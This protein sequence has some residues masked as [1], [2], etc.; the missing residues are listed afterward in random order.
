MS[1]MA[2]VVL[3]LDSQDIGTFR[4]ALAYA[5]KIAAAAGAADV[6]LLTHT[7]DQLDN[8]GLSRFLEPAAVKALTSRQ[9]ASLP[10]G[11]KLHGETKRT[12]RSGVPGAVII[13]YYADAELLDAVDGLQGVSGVVAVP[14]M[15]GE[16]DSWAARWNPHV[17]GQKPVTPAPLIDDPVV[18]RALEALTMAINVA[19]GL[20]HPRDKARA[21][22]FLRILRAKGHHDPSGTIKSWA[23]RHRW[24]PRGAADLEAL[25]KKIWSLKARPSAKLSQDQNRLYERW[26]AAE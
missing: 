11:R 13:A 1:K 16:A 25:A 19:T 18:V 21:D 20:G 5:E 24:S 4:L 10:S 14:W 2:R 6:I 9:T 3:P 17:H 22:E 12:L 23:I 8:T 15:L 26:Q 7:R